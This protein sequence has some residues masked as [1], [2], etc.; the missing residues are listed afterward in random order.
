MST[1]AFD[2]PLGELVDSRPAARPQRIA[3]T[4]RHVDIV[5]F[6]VG[7]HGPALYER[8]HGPEK[9]QLWA[10]LGAAPFEDYAAFEAYYAA[11]AQK[12]DP[13]LYAIIDKASGEAVGHATFMRI[14]PANRVIEVGNILYTPALMRTPG[15]TEAMELMAR[16]VFEALGYRRYEWKCNALNAPSRRAA[17]R[18]GF[19][20]EG[21]FRQHMIVKGR[22]RDTAWFSMLDGEWP[23]RAHAFAHWL[24]PENF[25]AEGR[26]LASLGVLNAEFIEVG[27]IRLRRASLADLP[28]VEEVQR[29]AYAKNRTLLGVE[30]V[31]LLWD[32]VQVFREREV[33]VVDGATALSAVLILEPRAGDLLL[34]SL[35]ISPMAQGSG[36]GNVL[37]AAADARA[38]ALGRGVVRLYTGEPLS[39]NINWYR[40][41]GYSIERVEQMPDRRLVH[42]A[43]ALG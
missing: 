11:A 12:D 30:P 20:F 10:Y 37:L 14:D 25:D 34:D 16:H 29:R 8:S 31:P 15:G 18:Y 38:Q 26:Q 41:K 21:V 17:L 2:L 24:A 3:L 27:D 39:A 5:P 28:A 7:K 1:D 6:D 40:R 35:A 22:N 36:L 9:E 4:G 23:Q 32:Y 43:K 19:R 33:W 13:L 42:M